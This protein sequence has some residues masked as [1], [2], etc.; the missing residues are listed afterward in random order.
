MANISR[1]Q[2]YVSVIYGPFCTG[3]IDFMLL[4]KRL[5]D[6]TN[7]FSPSFKKNDKTILEHFR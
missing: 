3:L 6:F 1:I 5:T 2:A 4:K 7:L